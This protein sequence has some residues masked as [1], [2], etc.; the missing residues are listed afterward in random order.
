MAWASSFQ[1][2]GQ[3]SVRKLAD[4]MSGADFKNDV[5]IIVPIGF[6]MNSLSYLGFALLK[7]GTMTIGTLVK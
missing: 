7:R 2:H 1:V 5:I 6:C 4:H 3:N